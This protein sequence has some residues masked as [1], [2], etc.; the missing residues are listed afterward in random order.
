MRTTLISLGTTAVAAL[1]FTAF[2][3]ETGFF[4]PIIPQ[5]GSCVCNTAMD[6]GCV[7]IVFQAVMNVLVSL[8]VLAVV[9]FIA[10]A[11]FTLI[12]GGSNPA[13][14]TKA[15]NRLV[16]AVI[17]LVVI[18]GAWLV[19]DTVMK[20]LYNPDTVFDSKTFGPWNEIFAGNEENYCLRLNK[21][22]GVLTTGSF[23]GEVENF[24]N[25]GTNVSTVGITPGS[26]GC[27]PQTIS[28]A[29][30]AGGYQLTS[31]QANTFSCIAKYESAC[32]NN[33][34]GATTQSGQTTT[35]HGMFQIVLGI[36]DKCHSLN[37]PV[38]TDAANRA[39]YQV[40]GN[41]NCSTAF[42]GGKVKPG[43]Q[44]LA[45]ACQA[46]SKNINCNASAAACLLKSNPSFSDWTSDPRSSKQKAC[47]AKFNT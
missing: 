5:S 30:A 28:S 7:L 47:I 35:A 27:A 25:S 37:L 43:M 9:F 36:N 12:T 14:R 33:I 45:A 4:G 19:V 8:S 23:V 29:A 15:R 6:W 22:P 40:T 3:A 42:S 20:T 16:N 31:A 13:S 32:G 11:G 46:A 18:L 21:N 17:G 26:G 41:L 10:W 44:K 34:S 39:G 38:C 1:P 2:A 24:F